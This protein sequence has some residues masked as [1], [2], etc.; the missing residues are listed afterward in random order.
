MTQSDEPEKGFAPYF[1]DENDQPKGRV[2]LPRL[3]RLGRERP[4]WMTRT[5]MALTAII[6]LL[7]TARV[8]EGPVK[9]HWRKNHPASS[10]NASKEDSVD[11][12]VE[13]A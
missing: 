11:R 9:A 4:G 10:G 13:R 12:W 3:M 1:D 2:Y 8:V 6:I 5:T 7:A